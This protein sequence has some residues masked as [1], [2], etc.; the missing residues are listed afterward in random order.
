M[1]SQN[2]HANYDS[3]A[4]MYNELWGPHFSNSA[5]LSLER[6]LLKNIPEGS[7]IF[8]LGCGTGQLAQN[9]LEKGYEV[10]GID[11]SEGMLFYA[12]K[13]APDGKF[14]LGDA[15]YF[16]FISTFQ[17]VISTS[18]SLNHIINFEELIGV[19]QNVY[20]SLLENGMFVF[21][22]NNEEW[23][24]SV[25]DALVGGD[26]RDEYAW[27]SRLTYQP[28]KKISKYQNTI[29]QLI[30][31]TWQR[32]D[33][34]WLARGYSI[35]EV[36][37]ALEKVGFIEINIYN[38]ERDLQLKGESGNFYFACRKRLSN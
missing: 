13:N 9:L 36:K 18:A 33:T 3:F 21:D 8:D 12:R 38:A 26:V 24:E 25:G 37:S 2:V 7:S 1:Y 19:F 22:L 20:S 5:L 34:T 28:A 10:T 23:Y 27:A 11:S 6:L 32:L 35:S 15:R 14:I 17:A 31:G 30:D 4:K 16:N 29:F